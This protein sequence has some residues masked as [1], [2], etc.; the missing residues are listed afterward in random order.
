VETLSKI[1]VDRGHS[2]GAGQADTEGEIMPD[3][4]T[5]IRAGGYILK[6]SN[7]ECYRVKY[8]AD[9]NYLEHERVQAGFP[10]YRKHCRYSDAFANGLGGS[11]VAPRHQNGFAVIHGL[12]T[13]GNNPD[14]MLVR[15]RIGG[16]VYAAQFNEGVKRWLMTPYNGDQAAW[17]GDQ[18]IISKP[19]TGQ[20]EPDPDPGIETNKLNAIDPAILYGLGALGALMAIIYFLLKK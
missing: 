16:Q 2:D 19:G 6:K 8:D 4:I 18:V 15:R 12:N 10:T 9:G 5:H 17:C 13:C 20:P 14:K 3:T 1:C 7:V 11:E